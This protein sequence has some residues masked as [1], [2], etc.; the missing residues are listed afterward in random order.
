MSNGTTDPVLQA[1]LADAEAS[2]WPCVQTFKT[3]LTGNSSAA[4][5]A[6]QTV[7]LGQCLLAALPNFASTLVQ[8]VVNAIPSTPPTP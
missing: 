1:L 6:A 7:L 3:N 8:D 2:F 4:N 5:V